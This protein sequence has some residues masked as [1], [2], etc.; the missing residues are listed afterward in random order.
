MA[1]MQVVPDTTSQS[2]A[3]L[4]VAWEIA[5]LSYFPFPMGTSSDEKLRLLTNAVVESYTAITNLK[6][7]A[8]QS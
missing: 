5:R 7:I 6:E 3:V 4:A 8:A 2:V 1:E